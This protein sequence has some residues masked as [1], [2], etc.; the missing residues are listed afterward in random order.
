VA[1]IG[2]KYIQS[3]GREYDYVKKTKLGW[4]RSN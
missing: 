3:F 1:R 2:E 4:N